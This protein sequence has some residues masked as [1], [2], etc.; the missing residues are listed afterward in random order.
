LSDT[1]I[2]V[3]NLSKSFRLKHQVKHD[4][5]RETISHACTVLFNRTQRRDSSLASSEEFWALKNVSFKI[6][7]GEALGIIGRNG[8]GKSTL[9]KIISRITRPTEGFVEITGRVGSLLEV[10]TGFHPELSGRENIHLNGSI[11][12][13]KR[14]DLVRK[15]DEIV[16][17]AEIERFLDTPVKRYSSGMYTRLAFAVAAHLEPEILV[18]DEVLAVG[19]ARF[20]KKC[21]GKMDEVAQAGRTI[22]FVSHNMTAISR[23]CRRTI[24]IDGG[25]IRR[26]G[27]SDDVIKA[28]LSE[29]MSQAPE[30]QWAFPGDAPGDDRIRLIG[31]R[32]L[33][34][35]Q[36]T[37]VV[38][39]NKSAQV[40]I[41]FQVLRPA[42][43]LISGINLYDSS[44]LCLFDSCDWRPNSLCP[45][46]YRTT[47]AIP[48]YLLAEGRI[49]V[50]V[51]LV[52][53]EP[54]IHS[55]VV[56]S[57]IAFDAVDS[58]DPLAV[59]GAYQGVW[60]G[61][62]RPRLDWTGPTTLA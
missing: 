9:L 13:M 50:L 16:S 38:D 31:A 14:A 7:R 40:Q 23:L 41:D 34:L 10:G 51:Q 42:E 35:D 56:P 8:A 27:D 33:Q 1:A 58:D 2:R 36:V 26:A 52:F 29:E 18:V 44:G 61:A 32:V 49:S 24:W 30:R 43:N 25:R 47:V 17:F 60:P 46:R 53:Y 45:N 3:D 59:R 5:L 62:L 55:V 20:Q 37:S 28:Y 22:L 12:G 11:L 6:Q 21:L 15:F 39:I 57:V 19:D 4:S 54:E 48:P